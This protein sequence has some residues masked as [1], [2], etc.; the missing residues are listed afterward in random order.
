MKLHLVGY[1]HNCIT[2]HGFINVNRP[3][4]F[5]LLCAAWVVWC[6]VKSGVTSAWRATQYVVLYYDEVYWKCE[7]TAGIKFLQFTRTLS[8][9]SG[10]SFRNYHVC[11]AKNIHVLIISQLP[12][13]LSMA[14]YN[15]SCSNAAVSACRGKR[16]ILATKKLWKAYPST[17]ESNATTINVA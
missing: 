15:I 13:D 12:A 7:Y 2:M 8:Y 10:F 1:F 17:V 16:T 14:A 3:G 5:R 9:T 6:I 4:P 11:N